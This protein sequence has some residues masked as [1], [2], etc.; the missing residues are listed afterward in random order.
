MV[1][2]V[3][4]D[5]QLNFEFLVVLSIILKTIKSAAST[6]GDNFGEFKIG[7]AA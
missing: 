2:G 6:T 4:S 3:D 1:I 7:R 5:R